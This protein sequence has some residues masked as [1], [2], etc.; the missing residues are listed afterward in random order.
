VKPVPRLEGVT[1][2]LDAPIHDPAVLARSLDQVAAVNRWLGARRALLRHLRGRLR[3]DRLTRILDVGTGSGD[4]PR[5]VA[6]HAARRGRPLELVAADAHPQIAA[7]A[8][9]RSGPGLRVAVADARSLPFPDGAF[10]I[11]LLSMTLHHFDGAEQEAVLRSVAR[12]VHGDIIIGELHRSRIHYLGARLLAAT[13]WRGNRLTRHDGPV[14]V[15]RGFVPDE[16]LR[17][18]ARA[19]LRDAAVHRHPFYRLVLTA[20]C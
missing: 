5:A 13:L 4:L 2:R 15:L 6:A 8:A 19:G 9:A 14:S 10:D 1:E 3:R 12:V 7:L 11:G 20:R 17:I 18:A 16:L